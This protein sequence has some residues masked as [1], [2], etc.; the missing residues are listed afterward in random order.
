MSD[1]EKPVVFLQIKRVVLRPV[2]KEDLP[3]IVRWFND[4]E[5]IQYLGTY[6]PMMEAD[7]LIWFE[8]LHTQKL[9]DVVLT[10]VVDGKAIGIMGLHKIRIKDGVART[11]SVIGEKEYWSRRYGKE[12][13]MLLLNY[14]F[15]T[16]GLRKICSVVVEF[17]ERSLKHNLKCGFKEEGRKRKQTYACGKYWD[18]ILL[19]V[20]R[21]EWLPLWEEFAEEHGI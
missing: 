3:S 20:F 21:E 10:I 5:V 7:K 15:N 1:Q 14:A 12:A 6:L 8:N 17:N 2:M 18:D 11:S 16:L 19:A 4:P 13:K 9:T